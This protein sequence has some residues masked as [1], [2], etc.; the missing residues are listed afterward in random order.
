LQQFQAADGER[1]GFLQRH[2]VEPSPSL[3]SL[4][5]LADRDGDGKLTA[6]ELSTFLELHAQG[7]SAVTTVT[8]VDQG[9]AL[10]ELLDADRDGRLSLRE[11]HGAWSRLR[12]YDRDRDGCV[13]RDELP[14][15]YQLWL[16]R[17][18]ARPGSLVRPSV[19]APKA[20]PARGP[21]WFRM[22]DVNGDGDVSRREFLGSDEAFRQLDTDGD[23]LISVEEAERYEDLQKKGPRPGG[24]RR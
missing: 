21:L 10:F 16:S 5:V 3:S 7:A 24:S 6:R 14:R 23:D 17:G 12:S 13:S 11:L 22:M 4:F 19:V 18:W 20:P 15:H 8:L 9:T 2:Q 1:K